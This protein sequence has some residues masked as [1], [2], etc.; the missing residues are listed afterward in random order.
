MI[1]DGTFIRL[2]VQSVISFGQSVK[3]VGSQHENRVRSFRAAQSHRSR[4]SKPQRAYFAVLSVSLTQ[5]LILSTM[6]KNCVVKN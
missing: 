5:I 4:L 2:V 3:I 1:G 6:R